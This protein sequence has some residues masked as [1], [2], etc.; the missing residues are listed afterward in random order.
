MLADALEDTY[1]REPFAHPLA[2]I[3]ILAD[4]VN[5]ADNLQYGAANDDCKARYNR[6]GEGR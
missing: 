5:G 2:A 3:L 4:S 1:V 6:S